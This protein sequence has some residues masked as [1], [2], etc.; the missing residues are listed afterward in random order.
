MGDV[1]LVHERGDINVDFFPPPAFVCD[2]TFEAAVCVL[3]GCSPT[4][5]GTVAVIV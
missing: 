1:C 4:V 3:A 5:A 2:V